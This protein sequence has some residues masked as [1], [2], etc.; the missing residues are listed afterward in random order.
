MLG[1]L[2]ANAE[3]LPHKS[4]R[5]WLDPASASLRGELELSPAPASG[6]IALLAGLELTL[7][8]HDGQRRIIHWQGQLPPAV[9]QRGLRLEE[10][11]SFL[12]ANAGWYPSLLDAPFSLS[13]TLELPPE[14][15]GVAS[16]SLVSDDSD[17]DA[18]REHYQHPRSDG[19]EVAAGPWQL[20]EQSVG[21]VR[22]RTLF[23]SALDDAFADTYL[24]HAANH[25][26]LFEARLGDYPFASFTIAATPA[27]VGLAFPGFTL[28]GERVIPLPF[29]PHTSLAHELMHAWWGTGV[30]L[31]RGAGN[32][33]EALTTYL[34]DYHLDE[35]RGDAYDTRSRW[36]TDL[37][38]L[39][40]AGE[41]PLI[42]FR[43]GRDPA[44][45]LIGYQHG[46]MVLHMLRQ[47]IGDDAFDRALR[48]LAD[49]HM[50][51]SA[52]WD[53]LQA[54]FEAAADTSLDDFFSAWLHQP[55]RPRIVLEDVQRTPQDDRWRLEVTLRQE[56]NGATWPLKLPLVIATRDA[57]VHH[58]IRLEAPRKRVRIDLDERPL[59]LQIDPHLDVLRELDAPPATLRAL[60]LAGDVEVLAA[61]PGSESLAL[62]LLGQ[63]PEAAHQHDAAALTLLVGLSD[64]VDDWL[65][66]RAVSVPPEV[67][68]RGAARMW[69]HPERPLV[70]LSADAP[71]GLGQLAAALRHQGQ[72]SYVIQDAD[73]A[74]LDSG[75]WPRERHLVWRFDD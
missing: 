48:E 75:R 18:T 40:A 35:L 6:E 24:H 45:R 51:H 43:G 23:P 50:F 38:A 56:A 29:I 1:S 37:A 62:Q 71:R 2:G 9:Q 47:R 16:G 67:E 61:S 27:P 14:Q 31:E 73:G 32:W 70:I 3:E 44:A 52:G 42:A 21:D 11:G 72:H 10:A 20:R 58:S 25:L 65:G 17:A 5:L 36:L 4:M 64:D 66:D 26:S 55:G 7:D 60:L 19:I 69:H 59:A 33:S 8:E 12:P 54:A 39:P 53:D 28:L 49:T 30:R 15:R 41:R 68:Q 34:A 22:L 13:L 63:R 57:E 74:T 46:A